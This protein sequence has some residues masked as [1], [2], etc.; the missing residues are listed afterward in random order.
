MLETGR[1]WRTTMAKRNAIIKSNG[2]RKGWHKREKFSDER[3]K[4]S[5]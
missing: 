2:D 1:V 5:D 4:F 3:E